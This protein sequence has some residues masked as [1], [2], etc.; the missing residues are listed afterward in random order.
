MNTPRGY[1][2]CSSC[3]DTVTLPLPW[4]RWDARRGV[5][6]PVCHHLKADWIAA[7]AEPTKPATMKPETAKELFKRVYQVIYE[8]GKKHQ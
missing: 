6:C 5:K 4:G 2:F 1:W 7:P 3:E 8:E